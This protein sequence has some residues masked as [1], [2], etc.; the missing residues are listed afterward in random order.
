MTSDIRR[1]ELTAEIAVL[2]REHL[3]SLSTARFYGWTPA[4]AEAHDQRADRLAV[5]RHELNTLDLSPEL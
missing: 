3:E 2:Q 4:T 5:L 1:A